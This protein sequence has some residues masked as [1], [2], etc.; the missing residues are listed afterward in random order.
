MLHSF[1]RASFCLLSIS[2]TCNTLA[3]E[4]PIKITAY[5]PSIHYIGRFD[6]RDKDGPICNWSACSSTIRFK[7]TSIALDLTESGGSAKGVSGVN[8]WQIILD[9]Q[10]IRTLTPKQG[11]HIYEIARDI[12]SGDHQLEVFRRTE[13]ALGVAQFGGFQLSAGGQALAPNPF[14]R[15]IEVIGDS[16]SCGYGNEA[17]SATEPFSAETENA[18]NTY[19]AI[20]ARQLNAEYVSICWTGMKVLG[21]PGLDK[22]YAPTTSKDPKDGSDFSTTQPQAVLINLGTNDFNASNPDEKQWKETYKALIFRVRNLFPNAMIY[23]SSSPM[24]TDYWPIDQKARTTHTRYV[25]NIVL[26]LNQ[27]GDQKIAFINFEAQKES[28]GIG[29]DWHPNVKTHQIMANTWV[30][31]LKHDLGW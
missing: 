20:A 25:R 2:A 6:T 13:S 31:S 19:G 30:E 12:P 9:G 26:E 29:A 16:I 23:L 17:Q 11:R 7:A 4:L 14:K 3:S 10:P 21:D 22:L 27:A 28:D 24:L 5:D 8:Q 18:H 15:R 1:H